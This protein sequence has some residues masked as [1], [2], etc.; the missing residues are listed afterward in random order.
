MILILVAEPGLGKSYQSMQFSEEIKMLDLE[1]RNEEKR[2]R[3]FD[4]RLL[5]VIPVKE[6]TPEY[7]DDYYK[8]YLGLEKS[9]NQ[10]VKNHDNIS[11]IIVDGISD[12]RNKYAKAKWHIEHPKRKNPMPTEYK[13]INDDTKI[14]LTPLI[15]LCRIKH[16]DLVMTA[17]MKDDYETTF[18]ESEGKLIKQSSKCGRV[19]ATQDWI[20]YDV[21][22]SL[23]HI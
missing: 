23:I 1:N 10:L 9:I 3:F 7:L 20:D 14:M 21:D 19:A 13:E 16:I 8:S 22:L 11:T 4:D 15:N 18:I 2:R 17:Q 12:I 6:Y 5:E